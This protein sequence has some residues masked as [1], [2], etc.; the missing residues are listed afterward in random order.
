MP[1]ARLYVDIQT[2]QSLRFGDRGIPRL[3]TELSRNLLAH[4]APVAAL[5]LNPLVPWPRRIHP[6]LARAPQ[7]VW[8]TATAFRRALREGPLIN[9]VISPFEMAR[10]VHATLAAHVTGVPEAVMVHDLIPDVF[11]FDPA[12]AWGRSYTRRRE[13]I[14]R[15][16]LIVTPSASTRRDLAERWDVD[17]ARVSVI[18]EAAAPFFSLPAPGEDPRVRVAS[19]LPAISRPYVLSVSGPDGHKNTDALFEAWARLPSSLRRNHQLVVVCT[20]PDA[21]RRAWMTHARQLGIAPDEIVLTGFVEDDVLRAL[22]QRASLFVLPSRYEGFGLPVLEAIRCGCPAITSNTSSL[23]EVLD[24]PGATFSP[25]AADEIGGLIE[26]ALSDS[27]Y[28]AEL[29]QRCAQAVERHT[30]PRVVERLLAACARLP[31][32]APTRPRRP[33]VALVGPFPPSPSWSAGCNARLAA[34]LA[35]RCELD[36]FTEPFDARSDR[37]RPS[38]AFRMFP[39]SA[40]GP[41]FTPAAYDAVVYTVGATPDETY[42][43]A[44]TY[45]GVVWLH[46]L[47][48]A[49]EALTSRAR[50]LIV[51]SAGALSVLREEIGLPLESTPAWVVPLAV[52]DPPPAGCR[53]DGEGPMPTFDEVARRVLEIADLDLEARPSEAS[54]LVTLPAA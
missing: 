34:H 7:L 44:R 1:G 14:R 6:D 17:P 37:S 18:G 42:R 36:C 11:G 52:S 5:A 28:R 15:A 54:A 4:H 24:W 51:S 31:E 13:W 9:F 26:R 20:L 50:G 35:S 23:P 19:E 29:E 49:D 22:Y 47:A 30:W 8:N 53:R 32:S 27:T 40:L 2:I 21:T 3:A 43:L 16:D 12:S 46:D 45:P 39:A 10:P 33:R 41:T 38:R 25:T 48:L